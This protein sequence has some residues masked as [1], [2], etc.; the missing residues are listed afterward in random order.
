MIILQYKR[1][2]MDG[3]LAIAFYRLANTFIF[4]I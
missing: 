1:K 3:Y 4:P 2:F